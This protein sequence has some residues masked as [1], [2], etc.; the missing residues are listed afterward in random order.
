MA[1]I[2]SGL[3][4]RRSEAQSSGTRTASIAI[5]YQARA[6]RRAEK[7]CTS[8]ISHHTKSLCRYSRYEALACWS[9]QSICEP[10]DDVG[11]CPYGVVVRLCGRSCASRVREIVGEEMGNADISCDVQRSICSRGYRSEERA[12]HSRFR[13]PECGLSGSVTQ[14][15]KG[16]LTVDSIFI[17]FGSAVA[18]RG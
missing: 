11:V 13:Q 7:I 5:R 3:Q 8:D 6:A 14:V 15:V 16:H 18:R 12:I 9:P 1:R 10:A 2:T 4:L 17:G